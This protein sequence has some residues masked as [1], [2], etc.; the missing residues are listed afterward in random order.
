MDEL[1]DLDKVAPSTKLEKDSI[2]MLLRIL[3]FIL[4]LTS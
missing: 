4:I 3:M 2:F 1:I